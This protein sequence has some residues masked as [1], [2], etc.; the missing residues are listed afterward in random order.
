M[1]SVALIVISIVMATV[2]IMLMRLLS[3]P[4]DE[5]VWR[6][7][8]LNASNTVA[9]LN[10]N[11][12]RCRWKSYTE[13]KQREWNTQ[14]ETKKNSWIF[15]H[16]FIETTEVLVN[17]PRWNISEKCC[18]W[19]QY[20]S[21]NFWIISKSMFLNL[22]SNPSWYIC[23]HLQHHFYPRYSPKAPGWARLRNFPLCNRDSE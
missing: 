10:S 3:S 6:Q 1:W 23:H 14:D 15:L 13:I 9:S 4:H 16:T 8:G 22:R 20:K 19:N 7:P 17:A 12:L 11:N 21:H 2:L 18:I 5:L